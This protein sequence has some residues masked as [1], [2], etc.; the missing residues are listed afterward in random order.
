MNETLNAVYVLDKKLLNL[1]KLSIASLRFFHPEANIYVLSTAPIDSIENVKNIVIDPQKKFRRRGKKDRI[2]DA[3]YLKL[4][5][6]EFVPERKVLFIDADTVVQAPLD[7]LWAQKCEYICAVELAW[8]WR[9][10]CK[11]LNISKY[12]ISGMMLMNCENLLKDNFRQKCLAKMENL[13]VAEW[14]HEE[15][16]I[17]AAYNDKINFIDQKFN[18]CNARTY[19]NPI[20][21]EDAVILHYV[22]GRRFKKQ[23]YENKF[24]CRNIKFKKPYNNRIGKVIYYI[25][26]KFFNAPI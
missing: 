23:M 7:E 10:R 19:D 13:S 9:E 12:A 26:E 17:N 16:L 11:E 1:A 4:Y 22:G 18:Y 5:I 6:P 21:I 3:A 8:G 15:T 20:P 2:S 25:K 24:L 14:S